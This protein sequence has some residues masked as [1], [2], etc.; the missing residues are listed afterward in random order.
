MTKTFCVLT[1]L[2]GWGLLTSATAVADDGQSLATSVVPLKATVRIGDPILVSVRVTNSGTTP[3]DTNRSATAFDCFE[4]I[5]PD[6]ELVPYS[7]FD[8]QVL[9]KPTQ[10]LPKSTETLTDA[11][12][13]TDKYLIQKPGRYSIRLDSQATGLPASPAVTIDVA[14]GE[15]PTADKLTLRLLSIR[16]E[17]WHVARDREGQ[18]AP[19][20]RS[21]VA[22]SALHLCRN[23]MRGEAVFVWFTKT[24]ADLEPV[25][26]ERGTSEYIGR[27]NGLYVYMMNGDKAPALWPT[28]G[29]EIRKALQIKEE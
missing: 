6:G 14:P 3:V 21:E 1:V 29:E 4:V 17:G 15:L 19:F 22:G 25:Q 27:A 28:A 24:R 9:F 7:G 18:I 2:C 16:P 26:P 13:L 8:G 10:V 20:G 12:D 11:F 23:H 5:D